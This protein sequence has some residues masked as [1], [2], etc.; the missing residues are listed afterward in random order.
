MNE[1]TILIAL[2]LV[3]CGHAQAAYLYDSSL[4]TTP[5]AQGWGSYLIEGGSFGMNSGAYTMDTMSNSGIR[6]IHGRKD[7]TLD[8]DNGYSLLFDLRIA[9]E[10]STDNRAGFS[11]IT[12]GQDP[13]R[14]LEVAF[15]NDSVWIYN[16]DFSK[17]VEYEVDTTVRREYK[18]QVQNHNF[19]LF[20]DGS[21]GI[22]GSMVDYTGFSWSLPL[23]S[24]YS[25]PNTL[26]F[27]DDTTSG[28]SSVE[29]YSV[30]TVPLP[31]AL[32][33]L[34]SGIGF[35][36]YSGRKKLDRD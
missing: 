6:A 19:D 28:A 9:D 18:L 12:V 31:S 33:L 34:A 22:S 26:I 7:Q 30:Q 23:P 21:L 14:S 17:G 2:L 16:S 8:T 35:L 27:G 13:T 1:K 3:I 15:W 4:G 11:F 24:P 36:G 29:I 10:I 32:I 25:I 20:V 5:A